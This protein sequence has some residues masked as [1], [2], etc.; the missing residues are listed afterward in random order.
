[1]IKLVTWEMDRT[2]TSTDPAERMK[3][4]LMMCEMVKKNI[5]SGTLQMWG[6]NPGAHTGF[7]IS[8]ADEKEILGMVAQYVPYVKFKVEHMLDV[9]EVIATLKS[10]EQQT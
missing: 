6:I 7:G 5:A 2:H 3:H 1:M 9:D 8:G 10:A 4:T